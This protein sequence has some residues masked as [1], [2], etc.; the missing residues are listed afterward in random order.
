MIHDLL[1]VLTGA[2]IGWFTVIVVY[3]IANRKDKDVH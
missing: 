2:V 3:A 1:L